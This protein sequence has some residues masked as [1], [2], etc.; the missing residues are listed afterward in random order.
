MFVWALGFRDYC[1]CLGGLWL[2]LICYY[3]FVCCGLLPTSVCELGSL[4]VYC[5]N[6]LVEGALA[7]ISFC[8]CR[9]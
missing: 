1:L 2:V 4:L 7:V 9:F 8:I 6:G 3:L 5:L